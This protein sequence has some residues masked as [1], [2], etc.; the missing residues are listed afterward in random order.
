M[1]QFSV[2]SSKLC[3]LGNIQVSQI[4]NVVTLKNI[5]AGMSSEESW[6]RT[7]DKV[8]IGQVFKLARR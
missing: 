2:S 4:I 6:S 5:F 8:I 7:N 3:A 1:V